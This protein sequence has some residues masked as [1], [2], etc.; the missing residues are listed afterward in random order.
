[1]NERALGVGALLAVALV[2]TAPW[3]TAA[4]QVRDPVRIHEERRTYAVTGRMDQE[5]WESLVAGARREGEELVFA[6]TDVSTEFRSRM[7]RG[8]EACRIVGVEVDVTI[9][10]TLPEWTPSPEAP[11]SLRQQWNRYHG[12]IRRHEEGHVRRARETA[13][14]LHEALVGL[15]AADCETLGERGTRVGERVLERGREEQARYDEETG[16]GR[17]QGVRWAIGRRSEAPSRGGG[18]RGATR[19]Q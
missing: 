11:I 19:R 14:R 3:A 1:M 15:S 4:A 2:F 13:R 8:R 6:W 5:V 18:L 10:V 12:A 9:V 16:H 17:A 7:S